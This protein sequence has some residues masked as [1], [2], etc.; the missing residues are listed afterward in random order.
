MLDDVS[1][2]DAQTECRLCL[3]RKIAEFPFPFPYAQTSI[4]MLLVHWAVSPVLASMLLDRFL[5]AR[6]SAVLV[7]HAICR[8]RFSSVACPIHAYGSLT[9]PVF[10]F[11][12][13]PC[14]FILCRWLA[15]ATSFAS[16]FFLWC[17]NYTALQLESPFGQIAT[18][19]SNES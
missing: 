12:L 13:M 2:C 16:I 18:Y 9:C 8:F 5:L 3:T 17:M 14:I 6:V 19:Y 15:A 11:I 10:L 4:V 1:C 7:W